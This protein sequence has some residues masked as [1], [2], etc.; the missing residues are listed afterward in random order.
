MKCNICG[1]KVVRYPLK[2]QQEKTIAQNYR[3][4]T[5]NWINLFKMDLQSLLLVVVIVFMVL[6][7][8]ADIKKCEDA[9]EHP[10]EFCETTNCCEVNWMRVNPSNM[11]LEIPMDQI[12]TAV[13]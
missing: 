9:I 7:Y 1:A 6:G 8:K 5:I 12:N 4:G 11:E 10:C 13:P 2:G 3:E